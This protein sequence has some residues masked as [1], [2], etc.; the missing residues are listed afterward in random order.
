MSFL[1]SAIDGAMAR[2][3]GDINEFGSL[4]DSFIDR[5]SEMVLLLGILIYFLE[6]DDKTGIVTVFL[7]LSGGFLVSYVRARAEGIGLVVKNGILT[8]LERL[9]VIILSLFF[10]KPIIGTLL[11]AIFGNITAI[12]RMWLV[13]LHVK[14]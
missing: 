6:I 13:K 14:K 7:A 9:V 1:N 12:Q 8:R 11:V 10:H 4:L 3:S 2:L 5:C